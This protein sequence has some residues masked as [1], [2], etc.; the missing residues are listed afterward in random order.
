MF[1]VFG[2]LTC[3]F[4]YS[5][6]Q[7]ESVQ[8]IVRATNIQEMFRNRPNF[9]GGNSI[10][11][12]AET[13]K[14]VEGTYFLDPN[15]K[16]GSIFL[17]ENDELLIDYFIRYQIDENQIEVMAFE[18]GRVVKINGDKV[19]SFVSVD[20]VTKAKRIFMN[21]ANFRKDEDNLV[22]FF[23]L[24]VEGD[25]TLVKLTTAIYRN[26]NYN[27]ALMM[28]EKNDRIVKR[29]T[30]YFISNDVVTLIP[31]KMKDFLEIFEDRKSEIRKFINRYNVNIKEELGLI[32]VFN[33]YKQREGA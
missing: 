29:D 21:Q 3:A 4:E 12:I 24:L 14:W 19:K 33:F 1:F 16:R 23:E 13:P 9:V 32:R 26:S 31:S 18:D 25:I 27:T 28:G 10:Y 22:G 2:I 17:Y 7:H 5:F 8:K 6:A 11:G 30:F 20:S 15:W